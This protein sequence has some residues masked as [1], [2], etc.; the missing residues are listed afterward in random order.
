MYLVGARDRFDGCRNTPVCCWWWL[1][2]T[3]AV[4]VRGARTLS[5]GMVIVSFTSALGDTRHEQNGENRET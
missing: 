4:G 5:R 3:S 1:C 2:A